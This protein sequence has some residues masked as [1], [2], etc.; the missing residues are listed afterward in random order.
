M[1]NKPSQERMDKCNIQKER[2]KFIE[3]L[4][5]L[6]PGLAEEIQDSLKQSVGSD[7]NPEMID[8][9]KYDFPFE[10]L[11]FEGGGVKGLAHCG[12]VKYLEE[13]G[14]MSDIKRV[15]GSSAGAIMAVLVAIGL[16]CSQLQEHIGRNTSEIF[17]DRGGLVTGLRNLLN[18]FGWHPGDNMYN[19]LGDLLRQETGSEDITFEQVRKKYGREVCVVV[20]NLNLMT[21]EYCHPKTTPDM[22]VRMAV[23]MSVSIP[24][25][26]APTVY[27]LHGTED[28]FIDGGVLCNYPV[29]CFDGWFL[30][31]AKGDNFLKRLQPLDNIPMLY[32]NRF[33]ETTAHNKTLGFLL[34][35]DD[36]IDYLRPDLE[37]KI[38]I[39]QPLRP[40]KETKLYKKWFHKKE[41][42]VK[43]KRIHQ[44]ITVAV[45]SFL[46]V[47]EECNTDEVNVIDREEL[48]NALKSESFSKDQ[49]EI[50]FGKDA[51]PEYVFSLLDQDGNGKIHYS[52]VVSFIEE[53]GIHIKHRSLGFRRN[54][55]NSLRSYMSGIK[56]TL[57]SNIKRITVKPNDIDRTVG[58]N[59]GHV[60]TT[61]FDLEEEDK[62]F[63]ILRGYN[64]C[65]AFLQHFIADNNLQP[66]EDGKTGDKTEEHPSAEKQ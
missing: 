49:A 10:N 3:H 63:V 6:E 34:Y 30:S 23:R 65:R 50:L 53:H 52:E 25:L 48:E 56:N 29:H 5:Q 58:I 26:F 19:W 8:P 43:S 32:E 13:I 61:D 4:I 12:A 35:A 66:R 60:D 24:G 14:A 27:S 16:N 47:L 62:E 7:N 38:G 17:L 59:T 45:D 28:V 22:P 57:M 2:Y 1:G 55:I 54:D 44:R 37:R 20:T 21:A 31:M 18:R 46:K 64:S 39:V 42:M 15:S 11:A 51:S 36:E 41:D 33:K 9:G 40:S